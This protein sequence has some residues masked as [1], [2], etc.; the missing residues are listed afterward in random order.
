M[1][2]IKP[3]ISHHFEEKKPE[4]NIINK[5]V[6]LNIE[7]NPDKMYLTTD[8]YIDQFGLKGKKF[9]SKAFKNLIEMEP[10][11]EMLQKTIEIWQMDEEQ[12]DYICVMVIEL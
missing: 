6:I 10:D 5:A 12:T 1:Y 2:H 4:T 9:G 11:I 3:F 8:G 7:Y